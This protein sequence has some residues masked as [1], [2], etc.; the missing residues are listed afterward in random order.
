[1][2]TMTWAYPLLFIHEI[3]HIWELCSH[4]RTHARTHTHTHTHTYI[5]ARFNSAATSTDCDYSTA[6]CWVCWMC[7]VFRKE[8]NDSLSVC[9][10]TLWQMWFNDKNIKQHR[11]HTFAI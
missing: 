11:K 2:K 8:K 4:T 5:Y 9:L 1:M 3:Q 6:M 7:R 10:S